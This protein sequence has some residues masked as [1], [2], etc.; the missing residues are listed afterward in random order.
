[1]LRL[2]QLVAILGGYCGLLAR[3][4]AASCPT[5]KQPL[6]LVLFSFSFLLDIIRLADNV[7]CIFSEIYKTLSRLGRQTV[8]IVDLTYCLAVRRKSPIVVTIL[9]K[10]AAD[11]EFRLGIYRI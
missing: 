11:V 5:P 8:L 10:I 7:K 6:C 4:Q 3:P 9:I 2:N 1:M